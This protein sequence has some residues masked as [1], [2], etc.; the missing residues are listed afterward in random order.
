[1]LWL[2][3]FKSD[4][5]YVVI[6]FWPMFPF[7]TPENNNSCF[8]GIWNYKNVKKWKKKVYAGQKLYI[9]QSASYSTASTHS[10]YFAVSRDFY[11]HSRSLQ[12]PVCLSLFVQLVRWY[13]ENLLCYLS[14]QVNKTLGRMP[15]R[16]FSSRGGSH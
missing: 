11:F 5:K 13:F 14:P 4:K 12:L 6:H 9:Y 7:Y 2:I 10:K 3:A 16:I 8:H 15:H 1:M